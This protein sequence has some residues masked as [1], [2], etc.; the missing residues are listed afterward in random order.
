MKPYKKSGGWRRLLALVA[1]LAA[2]GT[3]TAFEGAAPE[4]HPPAATANDYPHMPARPFS[5]EDVFR[6]PH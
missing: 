2:L 6:M 4:G 3:I 5:V 1:G